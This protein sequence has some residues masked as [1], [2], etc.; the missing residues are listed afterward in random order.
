MVSAELEREINKL[1][2][3]YIGEFAWPTVILGLACF[4]SFCTVMYLGYTGA[5][6]LW[7]G[8]VL[9]TL[10]LYADQTPL[11]DA[12]HGAVSG[13][14]KKLLWVNHL[15]GTLA[16][17]ILLH[18]Y[19]MFRLMHTYHH[20]DT[21]DR[22]LDPDA[23]V[24]G[25]NPVSVFLRCLTIPFK[26]HSYFHKKIAPMPEHRK[27]VMQ[28]YIINFALLSLMYVPMLFGYFW[29][30]LLLWFVPR[31]LASGMIVYFFG[32]LVHPE[33]HTD[34]YRNT[35]VHLIEGKWAWMAHWVWFFQCFHLIHHLFPKI[36]FYRYPEAFRDMR[37]LLEKAGSEI[38][39]HGQAIPPSP[40][41]PA[42]AAT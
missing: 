18:E 31:I 29:E 5:I 16:G 8:L 9:N 2:R 22:D 23:W 21:N 15:I 14:N 10:I 42:G 27:E 28:I 37:P 6:P 41:Q 32:Y 25:N 19:K 26:Y 30:S 13:R 17:A 36:P 4:I 24:F 1:A 40:N 39:V 38:T 3:P 11:H 20:R 34:R 35:K 12:V 7:L 33:E